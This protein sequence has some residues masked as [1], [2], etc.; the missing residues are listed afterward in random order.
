MRR[1]LAPSYRVRRRFADGPGVRE[2]QTNIDESGRIG[3]LIPAESLQLNAPTAL[4]VVAI[5]D[6]PELLDVYRSVFES[7]GYRVST[8]VDCA[9]EPDTLLALEPDLFIVDLRCGTGLGGL[10]L[11]RRLREHP[12]GCKVPVVA[13]TALAASTLSTIADELR[14]L[15]AHLLVK[16]FDLD[17]LLDCVRQAMI[18]THLPQ[19]GLLGRRRLYA[20]A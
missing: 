19:F 5:D 15:R 18:G 11:L 6:V 4:H 10:D 12:N 3:G 8:L 13:C 20:D 9:S 14:D 7:E 2:R 16:P 1:W 17:E